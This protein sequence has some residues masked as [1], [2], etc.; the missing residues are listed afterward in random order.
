ME[1]AQFLNG[2]FAGILEKD[3]L[4]AIEK[5][6]NETQVLVPE[7]EQVM[8][9]VK[10][11]TITSM[12]EAA[13][14]LA[15]VAKQA[16]VALSDCKAST[17]DLAIIKQWASQFTDI[18]TDMSIIFANA[19]ANYAEIKEYGSEMVQDWKAQ[20]FKAAGH[21]AAYVLTDV[22]GPIESKTLQDHER[23]KNG[24]LLIKGLLEGLVHGEFP[25]LD[26]CV[27][28]SEYILEDVEMAV[29]DFKKKDLQDIMKGITLV[30]QAIRDLPADVAQCKSCT[31]N[32]DAIKQWA[33]IFKHPLDLVKVMIPN[34]MAN[35]SQIF[36][37]IKDISAQWSNAQFEQVGKDVADI[38]TAAI[39][40]IPTSGLPYTVTAAS[41]DYIHLVEGLLYGFVQDENLKNIDTCITDAQ[42][43]EAMVK[44]AISDFQEGGLQSYIKAVK[45]IHAII[46]DVPAD[47]QDCKNVSAD[48]SALEQWAK[49]FNARTVASNAFKHVSEISQDV[50]V[51]NT[52]IKNGDYFKAGQDIADIVA[53][54]AGPVE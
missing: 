44:V 8:A 28:N 40:P 31:G 54:V 43:L 25:D 45:E 29:A 2:F 47:I 12:V 11:A 3:D 4:P 21:D 46:E 52:D 23:A 30:G 51:M 34:V 15:Q 42:N 32:I 27:T 35:E 49:G 38:L 37:D 1:A 5:C 20:S 26:T 24:A 16:P 48:I 10:A 39:G 22:L 36:G 19:L 17:S 50:S 41:T 18:K 9:D 53:L 13:K 6:V 7:V 14:I 33:Q